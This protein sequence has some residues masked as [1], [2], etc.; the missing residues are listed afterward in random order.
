MLFAVEITV[1]GG[2]V[3]IKLAEVERKFRQ[4]NRK[5]IH[6]KVTEHQNT[7]GTGNSQ[8]QVGG[9]WEHILNRY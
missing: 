2:C 1:V 4:I 9:S 6:Q 8:V 5:N 7:S 3:G